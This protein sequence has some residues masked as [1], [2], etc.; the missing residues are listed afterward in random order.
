MSW[1]SSTASTPS[2]VDNGHSLANGDYFE[3]YS[4]VV[5]KSIKSISLHLYWLETGTG[6][7]QTPP[8]L[9]P[10]NLSYM[11]IKKKGTLPFRERYISKHPRCYLGE[12]LSR[13]P[14]KE[15]KA[16]LLH[17]PPLPPSPT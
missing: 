6:V 2:K 3:I 16:P 7:I 12:I 14:I 15:D 11:S 10:R 13:I 5:W 8:L 1:S 9:S 4:I 17:A